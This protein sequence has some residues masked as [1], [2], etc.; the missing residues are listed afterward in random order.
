MADE[1]NKIDCES[2]MINSLTGTGYW[3]CKEKGSLRVNE[4]YCKS[5]LLNKKLDV[6]NKQAKEKIGR[7]KAAFKIMFKGSFF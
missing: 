6:E 1:E 2:L 4:E 7:F 5:C 3:F